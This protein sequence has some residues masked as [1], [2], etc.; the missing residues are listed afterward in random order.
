MDWVIQSR[1]V[2]KLSPL[3]FDQRE[4]RDGMELAGKFPLPLPCKPG[5][6]LLCAVCPAI[7]SAQLSGCTY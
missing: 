3:P 7:R 6:Q 1:G 5:A 4:I 2:E